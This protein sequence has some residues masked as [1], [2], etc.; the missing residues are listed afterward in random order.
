MENKEKI[1]KPFYKKWWFIAWI[2]ITAILFIIVAIFGKDVDDIQG[3]QETTSKNNIEETTNELGLNEAE[4]KYRS[5]LSSQTI[6]LE[7]YFKNIS[8]LTKKMDIN[9]DD[10]YIDLL[11]EVTIVENVIE[12]SNRMVIPEKFKNAHEKYVEALE[13]I[14]ESNKKLKTI[15]TKYEFGENESKLLQESVEALDGAIEI[16]EE[17]QME[18]EKVIGRD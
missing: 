9:S 2:S 3:V 1:K 12:S 14:D 7:N 17:C 8:N 15:A 16:I 18:L 10:W 4:E 13:K 6:K 11:T 5:E